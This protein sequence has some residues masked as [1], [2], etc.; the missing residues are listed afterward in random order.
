MLSARCSISGL[1]AATGRPEQGK[2][3]C[4]AFPVLEA[5]IL[6]CPVKKGA[7]V[8]HS[9]YVNIATIC[10]IF[11][12]HTFL[13]TY[14]NSTAY[15]LLRQS[16]I[17]SIVKRCPMLPLTGIYTP[18]SGSC[19]LCTTHTHT[20][21]HTQTHTQAYLAKNYIWGH[22]YQDFNINTYYTIYFVI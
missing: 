10:G 3:C 21:T 9:T 16:L 1:T 18:I 2:T 5:F 6:Y 17:D 11:L 12:N 15:L 19:L 8:D 22:I 13:A 7:S 4:S 20:H 14:N